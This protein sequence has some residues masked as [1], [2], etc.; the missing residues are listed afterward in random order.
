M[1][2]HMKNKIIAFS[3]ICLLAAIVLVVYYIYMES[4]QR[5]ISLLL[6]PEIP[7]N[8]IENNMDSE[9]N[10]IYRYHYGSNLV[11]MVAIE[12]F[13]FHLNDAFNNQSNLSATP[14]SDRYAYASA[15]RMSPVLDSKI[16]KDDHFLNYL[17]KNKDDI[18]KYNSQDR[19]DY[20]IK[21][22]WDITYYSLIAMPVYFLFQVESDDVVS[23]EIGGIIRIPTILKKK[24]LDLMLTN[25]GNSIPSE[26]EPPE[27]V[28]LE[29]SIYPLSRVFGNGW[30][31]GNF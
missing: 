14:I 27:L 6:N 22:S 10:D 7:K 30:N 1:G 18:L 13:G 20:V 11:E 9:V 12:V 26:Y 15:Y 25:L 2:I 23:V 4:N 3:L 21:N 5:K 16:I 19:L 29:E 31:K 24:D 17:N 8:L 28:K